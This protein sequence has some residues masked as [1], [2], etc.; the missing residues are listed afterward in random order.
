MKLLLKEVFVFSCIYLCCTYIEL[1]Q[2][3]MRIKFKTNNV[4]FSHTCY[5]VASICLHNIRLGRLLA[6][7]VG[8]LWLLLLGKQNESKRI[9]R[10]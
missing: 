1:S 6:S 4:I 5:D 7:L 3:F 9:L 2:N 10:A 8:K